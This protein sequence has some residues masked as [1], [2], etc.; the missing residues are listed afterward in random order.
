VG[1][2]HPGKIPA[3]LRG[4]TIHEKQRRWWTEAIAGMIG[5]GA[6]ESS[7]GGMVSGFREMVHVPGGRFFMGSA[8][9]YPEEQP[10]VEAKVD[11]LWV[12]KHPVTNAEFRRFV[13]DT[14]WVTV[15]E[16]A[17]EQEDFP[18]AT[19]E[20]LV[21][22]SQVF[23]L[24]VGAVPLDDWRRWWRWQPGADWRHPEGPRSTL[25]GLDRHPVVHVG[26]EDARAYAGWADKRLPTEVE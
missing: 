10:V 15:A 8:E 25:N 4:M 22:G 17:P 9:F 13:K 5:S 3:E 20:Q 24:T 12:D 11:D 7:R 18:D 21:P 2:H 6:V 14:G 1:R 23:T 19:P 16:R 26:W